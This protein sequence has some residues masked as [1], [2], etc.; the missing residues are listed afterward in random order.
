MDSNTFDLGEVLAGRGYPTLDVP[1]Y[2]DEATA[3]A[4]HQ[5]K[6]ELDRLQLLGDKDAY[7]K[8]EADLFALIE[9]VNDQKYVFS[10][11]GVPRKVKKDIL[12]KVNAKHPVELDLL[13][14]ETPS[15]DRDELYT[16]LIWSV[17][18]V[19][20]TAPSGKKIEAPSVETLNGFRDEA[21]Q[22]AVE[23]VQAGIDELSSGSKEGFEAAARNT[24][25]LSDASPED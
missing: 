18:V 9:K 24:D 10:L 12:L 3:F 19:S 4:I 20:I 16:E 25:F 7:A 14:R 21:P 8:V 5:A 15:M 1:V 2:L 13:G 6:K 23:A 11:K 17:H 22:A